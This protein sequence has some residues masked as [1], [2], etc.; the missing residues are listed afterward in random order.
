MKHLPSLTFLLLLALMSARAAEPIDAPHVSTADAVAARTACGGPHADKA[1][2]KSSAQAIVDTYVAAAENAYG[3]DLGP[4]PTVEIRNTPPLIYIDYRSNKIVVP[5]WYTESAAVR[6]V[7]RTFAGGNDEQAERLFRCYFNRF[8]IAHE[9][10]HWF[11]FHA[12]REEASDYENENMANR[13]A[14]A[15]WRTQPGSESFLD[16]LERLAV[17]AAASVPD[18][19]P[20]GDDPVAY[21]GANY[22][23]ISSQPLKYGYYQW[24]FTVKALQ[25]RKQ[26]DFARMVAKRP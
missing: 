7:F 23:A 18:P 2:L 11:Q 9:A 15:F 25:D 12:H 16:E 13:M 4:A 22:E 8:L 14:V 24:K 21:L 26:L 3:S 6:S 20:P 19:T 5:F 10:S 1:Q 17:V